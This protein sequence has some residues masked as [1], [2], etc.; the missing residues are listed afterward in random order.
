MSDPDFARKFKSAVCT[1]L[2]A[3]VKM[4]EGYK[5]PESML[6]L[7]YGMD[8]ELWQ[9]T[10]NF[11]LHKEYIVETGDFRIALTESGR[12]MGTKLNEIIAKKEPSNAQV[13]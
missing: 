5:A 6:Y 10:K 7:A 13:D 12:A 1:T 8:M 3:L 2:S 4:D 11:L 9:V